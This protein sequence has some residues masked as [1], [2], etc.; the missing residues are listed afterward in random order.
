MIAI[1]LLLSL[2]PAQTLSGKYM[3][4]DPEYLRLYPASTPPLP[5]P[6]PAR[7]AD[8]CALIEAGHATPRLLA[9][10]G[11]A[12]FA[13]GDLGLAYRALR[14]ALRMKHGEPQRIIARMNACPRVPEKVIAAE[15]FE[16]RVWVDALQSFERARIAA[17]ED[18][19][20]RAGFF[21]QYGRPGDDLNAIIRRRRLKFLAGL[22]AVV[23]VVALLLF[24]M[25]KSRR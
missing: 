22:A 17:G 5:D 3:R 7:V 9:A 23:L 13:R 4:H 15:E 16:A 21:E 24:R 14:R 19:R 6:L 2:G 12:L 1:A 8:L 11:E 25:V 20:E 18:P 10:L